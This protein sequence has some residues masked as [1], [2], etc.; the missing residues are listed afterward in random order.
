MAY[1]STF[2]FYLIHGIDTLMCNYDCL[3]FFL[4]F[5]ETVNCIWNIKHQTFSLWECS[6]K[7]SKDVLHLTSTSE[8]KSCTRQPVLRI[9]FTFC[10]I[11]MHFLFDTGLHYSSNVKGHTVDVTHCSVIASTHCCLQWLTCSFFVGIFLIQ[12]KYIMRDRLLVLI[13]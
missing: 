6:W 9:F 1:H 13:F 7:E 12:Y 11:Y 8:Y 10:T 3:I 2:F 5:Q 4:M